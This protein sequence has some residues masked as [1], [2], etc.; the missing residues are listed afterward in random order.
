MASNPSPEVKAILIQTHDFTTALSTEP[1][2]VAVG[3]LLGK[4]LTSSEVYSK[5]LLHTCTLTE[6]V[7]IMVE[8]A[9][10]NG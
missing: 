4:E 7:A 5:V 3:I 9:R 6:K 2:G 10:E 8:S 1:L